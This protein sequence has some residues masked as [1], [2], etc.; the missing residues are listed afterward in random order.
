MAATKFIR[1]NSAFHARLASHGQF[2]DTMESILIRLLGKKFIE[3]VTGDREKKTYDKKYV[4]SRKTNKA[5]SYKTG[6]IKEGKSES[7]SSL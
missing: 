5:R 3:T 1:V 4:D 2:G 6:N 7:L